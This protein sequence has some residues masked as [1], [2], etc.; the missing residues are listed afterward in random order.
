MQKLTSGFGHLQTKIMPLKAFFLCAAIGTLFACSGKERPSYNPVTNNIPQGGITINY[1]P[2]STLTNID[3]IN[4]ELSDDN[5]DIFSNSLAWYGTE[6]TFGFD[7]IHGKSA[8]EL[9]DI[10]NCL[11][12]SHT[13]TQYKC[14]E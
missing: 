7:A 4:S 3:E 14:V 8:S 5:R 12:T 6:A 9:I 2:A 10:V 13:D 11:K 1:D